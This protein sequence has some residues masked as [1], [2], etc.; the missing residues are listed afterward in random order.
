MLDSES[1]MQSFIQLT[2]D[3]CYLI[4]R[5]TLWKEGWR[6]FVLLQYPVLYFKIQK[7]SSRCF[8]FS[9]IRLLNR[10]KYLQTKF[11]IRVLLA[12]ITTTTLVEFDE[13][14]SEENFFSSS[15]P[16]EIR[17][18]FRFSLIFYSCFNFFSPCFDVF[19][20]LWFD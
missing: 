7:E 17:W 15:Y 11:S 10:N 14:L 6:F 16:F 3:F 18:C 4:W 9:G 2:N 19:S 5:H 1:L 8:R 13:K 20:H 12:I